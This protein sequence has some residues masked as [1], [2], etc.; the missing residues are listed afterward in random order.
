VVLESLGLKVLDYGR[1]VHQQRRRVRVRVHLAYFAASEVPYLF[2]NVVNLSSGRDVEVTHVWFE[3]EPRVDVL[4]AERPL[5]VRLR[6]DES[7]EAWVKAAKVMS[8]PNPETR[9]RVRLSSGRVIK[10][11]RNRDVPPTGFVPGGASA[12][13]SGAVRNPEHPPSGP[14]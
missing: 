1:G 8:V 14:P 13:P 2:V 10:S 9:A 12:L 7:W 6:P 5:P 11:R 4:L 3:I